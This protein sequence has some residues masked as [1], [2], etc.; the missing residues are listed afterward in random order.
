MG[1]K[2]RA[3][4]DRNYI[5]STRFCAYR[6]PRQEWNYCSNIKGLLLAEL[7]DHSQAVRL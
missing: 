1:F 3:I 7:I 6:A 5:E 4:I 2:L